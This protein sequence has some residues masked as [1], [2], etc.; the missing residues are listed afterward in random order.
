[1]IKYRWISTLLTLTLCF[2]SYAGAQPEKEPSVDHSHALWEKVLKRVVVV[3]GHKSSIKYDELKRS[4]E[5]LRQYINSLSRVSRSRFD[6]FSEKE[7]LAFLIN[8][9][10]ALTLELVIQHYPVDSIKDIGGW[11]STPWKIEF[12]SLFGEKHSLDDI[13]H[14]M[15]RK[16][17]DEPRIH[18]AL[19][20]AARSCPPLRTEP[21]RASELDDQLHASAK[22]FLHDED[23]NR[24]DP[25]RQT[26]FLSSVFKWYGSDFN[27]RY[28]S[29]TKYVSKFYKNVPSRVA[30]AYLPYDWSL[31]DATPAR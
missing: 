7:Q 20:C 29:A 5:D 3:N 8:A 27:S 25:A 4:P 24:F 13:E 9:Y 1:M 19:V 26:L 16:W 11:F 12:F 22:N 15:I 10:N 21:F 6:S 31:N 2:A 17:Y 18:F 23:R 14:Q 30:I 28:G